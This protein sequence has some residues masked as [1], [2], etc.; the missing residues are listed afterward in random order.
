MY[1]KE[2]CASLK[3]QQWTKPGQTRRLCQ[4]AWCIFKHNG[5]LFCQTNSAHIT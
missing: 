3:I 4:N 5:W 2:S 1:L